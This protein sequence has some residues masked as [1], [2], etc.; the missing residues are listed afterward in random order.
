MEVSDEKNT[1]P[2]PPLK[3]AWEGCLLAH[4]PTGGTVG[5]VTTA[6]PSALTLL[7]TGIAGMAERRARRGRN[8]QTG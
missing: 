3:P 6:E 8:K 4:T 7:A 2:V 1:G 5:V